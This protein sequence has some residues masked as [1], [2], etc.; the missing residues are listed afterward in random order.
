[1]EP[2]IERGV[3]SVFERRMLRNTH[4]GTV[5]DSHAARRNCVCSVRRGLWTI[6]YSAF[7][8]ALYQAERTM[9]LDAS[10]RGLDLWSS[11]FSSRE[12]HKA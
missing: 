1:M 5:F 3:D 2:A 6:S 11:E 10:S 7:L 12:R 4:S 9:L 8:V